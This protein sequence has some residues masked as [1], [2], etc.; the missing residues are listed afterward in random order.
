M[1]AAPSG[2][3]PLSLS[4]ASSAASDNGDNLIDSGTGFSV[5]FGNKVTGD[6]AEGGGVGGGVV[7]GL[8]Y[9]IGVGLAVA[10]AARFAWKEL[11]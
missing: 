5:T 8:I 1:P 7:S 10:L 9:D 4:A 11:K 6:G 3:P 2:P